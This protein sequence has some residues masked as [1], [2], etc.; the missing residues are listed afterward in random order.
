MINSATD[1][2]ALSEQDK[3]K[4]LQLLANSVNSWDW[5]AAAQDWVLRQDLSQVERLGLSLEDLP[6]AAAQPKPAPRIEPSP[7]PD[8]AAAAF[9]A[10][11]P[12]TVEFEVFTWM[13]AE[14]DKTTAASNAQR[15]IN[16]NLTAHGQLWSI[17]RQMANNGLDAAF[18]MVWAAVEIIPEGYQAIVDAWRDEF[19]LRAE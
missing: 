11:S 13:T 14:A 6:Q 18:A 16:E 2:E 8:P 1:L 12:G 19:R 15:R 3:A 5:D 10:L 9:R 17:D 4:F 7:P